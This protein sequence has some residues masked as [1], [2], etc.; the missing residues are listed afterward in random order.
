VSVRFSRFASAVFSGAGA[1]F[2]GRAAM[3]LLWASSRPLGV[4]VA[5]WV[6]ANALVPTA[7]VIAL[8]AVVAAVPAA[9][10]HGLASAA[11]AD[12]VLRLVVAALVYAVSLVLSPIG[13]ALST[14]ARARITGAL[15]ARLLDAVSA[16]IGIQHLEDQQV[17]DRLWTAEGS[18]T[19]YFP[20]DARSPGPACWPAGSPGSSA[21]WP[22]P[23]TTG[24]WAWPCWSSGWWCAG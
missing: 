17:L 9:S 18:L 11:G 24:G 1:R 5:L 14:A 10:A 6:L 21:A 4:A 3:A 13:G 16:P 20:G 8:G 7:V 2:G 15:Q 22:W 23:S 19:G 12:L